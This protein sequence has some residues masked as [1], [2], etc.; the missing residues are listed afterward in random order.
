MGM[1]RPPSRVRAHPAAEDPTMNMQ[2]LL[3]TMLASRMGGRG[4]MGGALGSAAMMGL[5][6]SLLRSKAGLAT[7]GY[8]AYRSYRKNQGEAG[9][10]PGAAQAGGQ[11]GAQPGGGQQSLG[12]MLGGLVDSITGGQRQ[13]GAGGGSLSDRIA[14]ALGGQGPAPEPEETMSDQKALLLIRAM[15]AAAHS[16]GAITPD[17]RARICAKLE[18]AGA[19][20]EEK[21]LIERELENP[22]PLDALLKEVGDRETAQQ[23]YMASRAAVEGASPTQKSYL[24]YLRQRL[25]LP[26]DDVAAA[27]QLAGE[28]R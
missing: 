15:I 17:E 11:A 19:D 28:G 9:A 12:G 2:R 26:E 1:R 25:D 27:E 16:D 10:A 22:K 23:F 24:T 21:R 6:G 14:G 3:G 8:L 18:E 20:A 4:G 13:P 5:G 7:L